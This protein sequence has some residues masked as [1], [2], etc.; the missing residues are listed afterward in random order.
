MSWTFQKLSLPAFARRVVHLERFAPGSSI[1]SFF[2]IVPQ[3]ANERGVCQFTGECQFT[4]RGVS[5]EEEI[6]GRREADI[7]VKQ[8]DFRKSSSAARSE[9]KRSAFDRVVGFLLPRRRDTRFINIA[10]L[11]P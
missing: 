1:V 10:E 5:T 4:L 9:D 8:Q 11:L 6:G 3:L 2:A 7:K